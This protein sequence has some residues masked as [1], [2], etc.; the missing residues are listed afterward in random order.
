MI[1]FI[2]Q[3]LK[4]ESYRQ[5]LLVTSLLIISKFFGLIRT[6]IIGSLYIGDSAIYSDI[7]INAQKIQDILIGIL[8]MGT[9]LSTLT[10]TGTKI[11]TKDG[12]GEFNRYIRYNFWV[13]ISMFLVISIII[14]IFIEDILKIS[15]R[16]SYI[17]YAELGLSNTFVDSARVLCFGVVFFAANTLFQTYLNIKNS[18]FWNNLTGIISN[19]FIIG[20]LIV[21]PKNFVFPVSLALIL[22][23]IVSMMV[24][25]YAANRMGLNWSFFDLSQVKKDHKKFKTY[26]VQDFKN[27]IPKFFIIQLTFVA[28]YF[29][30]LS[31]VTG[32]PTFYE[33]ASNIQGIFLTIIGAV[34]M[35]ILPKLSLIFHKLSPEA[36]IKQINHYIIKLLPVTVVGSILT[37]LLA[38]Y[39]LIFVLSVS[40]FKRGIWRFIEVNSSEVLQIQIIQILA[41][42]IIFLTINEVLVKYFLIQNKVKKLL[43]INTSSIILFIILVNN[44]GTIIKAEYILIVS[45]SYVIVTCL[46][47]LIYY[48]SMIMD[49]KKLPETK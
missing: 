45:I 3:K 8:I 13:F 48:T 42:S 14:S 25:Y 7:F 33:N 4:T 22:S 21:S 6:A 12:E 10:P 37:A 17:K 32:Y 36:F 2:K 28:T 18:F 41:I 16:D 27:I 1:N 24:H 35:V 49:T 26:F 15:L 47:S 43:L 20:T 40:N 11:L 19:L 23:F 39:L 30:S 46:Q 29:V 38:K 44:L 31:K 34:G 9:L 5:I